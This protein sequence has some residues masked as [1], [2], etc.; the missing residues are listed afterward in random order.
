MPRLSEM[1]G[2]ALCFLSLLWTLWFFNVTGRLIFTPI[3]PM[4]EDDF[5]LTHFKT[6]SIFLFQS[7][8]YALGVILSGFYAGRVGFKKTIVISFGIM[9]CVSFLLPFTN[10]FWIFY[11]ILFVIGFSAGIYVPAVMPLIREYFNEKHLSKIIPIYDSAAPVAIFCVPFFALLLLRF[12]QWREIFYV[13]GIALIGIC[14]LFSLVGEELKVHQP[15]KT[16]L[17]ELI[18]RRSLWVLTVT[19]SLTMGA[20]MGIY[21]ILPLFLT[22]EL[23]LGIGHANSLLGISRFGGIGIAI[24]CGFLIDR[25]ELRKIMFL[26]MLVSGILTILL[27]TS[28]TSSIGVLL[29]LQAIFITAIMPVAFVCI[30]RLFNKDM[31]SMAIGIIMPLGTLFGSGLIPYLLGLSGDLL[32]FRFG[33][34]ILGVLLAL[35]SWF[36]MALKNPEGG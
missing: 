24:L 27:G 1:R 9:A 6:T 25:F 28:S 15:R 33:I 34:V 21:N 19:L 26:L 13:I 16:M 5:V 7:I 22:K 20:N 10:L 31:M 14:A 35:T 30:A 3:L 23:S 32:S 29:L 17:K 18:G 12:L 4:I 2:K 8:G 36:T 11:P